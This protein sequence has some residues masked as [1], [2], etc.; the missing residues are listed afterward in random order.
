M[1]GAKKFLGLWIMIAMYGVVLPWTFFLLFSWLDFILGLSPIFSAG[2]GAILASA[3][4][5]V[6]FFWIFWSYSYLHFIGKGT[7]VEAFGVALHPTEKLVTTGPYAYTRNPMMFGALVFL[8]A[9][10]LYY[11]SLTGLILIPIILVIESIYIVMF[12]EPQLRKRFGKDYQDYRKLV[13][14]LFPRFKV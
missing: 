13:P 3:A 10:A 1:S 8:L 6:G 5:L 4:F 14:S 2:I 9:I 7:P 12:E 11:R